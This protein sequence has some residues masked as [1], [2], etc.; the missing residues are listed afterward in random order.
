MGAPGKSPLLSVEQILAKSAESNRLRKAID[1]ALAQPDMSSPW[2]ERWN[3]ACEEF[4]RRGDELGY[5][6]GDANFNLVRSGDRRAVES[7][8]RF[9]AADPMHFRSGYI[10]QYLWR[11][12]KQLQVS[13]PARG[14]LERAALGYLDRVVN[15]EFWDM[16]K[17]M[18]RVGR[19]PFWEDVSRAARESAPRST[20]AVYLLVHGANLH[21][22]AM[23]RRQLAHESAARRYAESNLGGPSRQD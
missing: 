11:W 9:L 14:R 17:T 4:H 21:A 10:K 22:G 5:P 8:L 13:E 7:A 18:A 15:R 20:R 2:R 6:G 19:P 12:F 1:S 3:A 16:A 23:L